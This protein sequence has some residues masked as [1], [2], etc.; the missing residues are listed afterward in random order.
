[1]L[2]LHCLRASPRI[3]PRHP[4]RQETP[5]KARELCLG[6]PLQSQ[7]WRVHHLGVVTLG[8]SLSHEQPRSGTHDIAP[9]GVPLSRRLPWRLLCGVAGGA[10]SWYN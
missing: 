8:A 9:W 2:Y 5:V 1:M 3:Q 6:L 4:R 10:P 7:S